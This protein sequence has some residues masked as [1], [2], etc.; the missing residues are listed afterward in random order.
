MGGQRTYVDC[1]INESGKAVIHIGRE[2]CGLHP[3]FICVNQPLGRTISISLPSLPSHASTEARIKPC[4]YVTDSDHPSTS[5]AT[6]RLNSYFKRTDNQNSSSEI[7][8]SCLT[9]CQPLLRCQRTLR[10]AFSWCARQPTE[11][12]QPSP[13]PPKALSQPHH[14]QLLQLSC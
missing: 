9:L 11:S 6:H 13:N 4:L 2:F 3:S 14:S 12:Q 8:L 5:P 10:K 7:A 1:R